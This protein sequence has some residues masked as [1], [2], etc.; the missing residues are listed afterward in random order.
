MSKREGKMITSVVVIV[1]IINKPPLSWDRYT[2]TEINLMWVKALQ[3]YK[4]YMQ[5]IV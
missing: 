3:R 2:I 1:I 5:S 4:D